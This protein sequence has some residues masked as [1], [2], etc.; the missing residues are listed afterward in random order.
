MLSRR[1]VLLVFQA[2]TR[3]N[4][5]NPTSKSHNFIRPLFA[6]DL[7]WDTSKTIVGYNDFLCTA[8]N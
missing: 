7:P 1:T 3:W 2:E 5:R 6:L 8:T 4:Q